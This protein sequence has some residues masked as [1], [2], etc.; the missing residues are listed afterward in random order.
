MLHGSP[1]RTHRS[2]A[3]GPKRLA[4]GWSIHF[5]APLSA[6]VTASPD[7]ATLYVACHDGTLTAVARADG[8]RRW[9]LPLGD[10]VYSAPFVADDGTVHVGS[11]RKTFLAVTPEGKVRYRLEV[12]GEADTGALA[13]PNGTVAFAAGRFLYGVRPSG[14][15][16][17]RFAAR[18]KIFTAPALT[19]DGLLVVGSQDDHV[20][21]VD[22]A[23]RLVWSVDLG[24]DV[25]G[26][27]AVADDGS[28]VVGTDRGEVVRLDGRG[29]ILAR[30]QVSGF[31]RGPL[32]LTRSGD[33]VVG[34]FGPSPRMVRV[35]PDGRLV[36]A[37]PVR[38]T[39]SADFGIVGGPV[40]DAEGTLFFGT[41]ED[42]V[43]AVAA[44]STLRWRFE[45]KG[46]VDAPLTLLGDGGLVVPSEDGTLTLLLP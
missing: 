17:F 35:A 20:H 45:S 46:D 26:A 40:E 18:G 15:V 33:V 5:D 13:M 36:G 44:D 7:E 42:A 12:E 4:V 30:T 6:Q 9:S 37:F 2:P 19:E 3:T 43:Y 39:G 32:S 1:R 24:A 10:R 38:G 22:G 21:A 31:V 11:D 29:R 41:Q 25:D 28:I 8:A 14:D 23:G 27:P 16:A 34:T